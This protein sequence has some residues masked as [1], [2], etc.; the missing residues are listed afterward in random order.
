MLGVS[1]GGGRMHTVLF[2]GGGLALL[3]GM[4]IAGRVIGEPVTALRL[5]LLIWLIVTAAH[6]GISV[7]RAGYPLAEGLPLALV[8]FGGPAFLALGLLWILR[9]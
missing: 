1:W 5:F 4:A 2:I 7:Q 8:I 6:L 3:A 9:R